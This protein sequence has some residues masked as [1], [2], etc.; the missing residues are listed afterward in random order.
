LTDASIKAVDV[1]V[2]LLDN[3]HSNVQL[4]AARAILEQARKYRDEESTNKPVQRAQL[5][6]VIC[7][8]DRFSE[9]LRSDRRFEAI[10]KGLAE[11]A[12]E[13]T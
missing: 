1:L 7:D 5:M 10:R 9:V 8:S 13:P 6:V 4:G 2:W 12:A 11:F 3:C